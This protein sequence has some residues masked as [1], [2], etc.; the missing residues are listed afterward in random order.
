MQFEFMYYRCFQII[1]VSILFVKD[2]GERINLGENRSTLPRQKQVIFLPGD[3]GPNRRRD[4]V[5]VA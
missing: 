4:G 2:K 3:G 1:L 5:A